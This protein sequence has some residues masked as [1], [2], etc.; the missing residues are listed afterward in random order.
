M[1]AKTFQWSEFQ[2]TKESGGSLFLKLETNNEYTVRLLFDPVGFLMHWDPIRARSPGKDLDPLWQ[3]GVEPKPR[4]ASWVLNRGDGNRAQY[5]EFPGSV[6]KAIYSWSSRNNGAHAGGMKAPDFKIV[7]TGTGKSTRYAVVSVG[8]AAP[9]GAAEIAIL[10]DKGGPEKMQAEI[11]ERYKAHA[12]QE[13]MEMCAKAGYR[14]SPI[15]VPV[16]TAIV[17]A[18]VQVQATATPPATVPK[19]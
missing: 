8:E 4:F 2:D 16:Q 7:V 18:P 13:I 15:Q 1:P 9:I 12:T 17:Q 11:Q 5:M 14:L 10:S 19:W 3:A 6:A